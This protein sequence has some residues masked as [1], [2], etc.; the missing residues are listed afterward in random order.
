MNADPNTSRVFSSAD[1]RVIARE[2]HDGQRRG[3]V[4]VDA[5]VVV[6]DEGSEGSDAGGLLGFGAP[7]QR[8][9]LPVWG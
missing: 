3:D 4:A 2:E 8:P 1:D 9:G 5:E 7:R 6:L